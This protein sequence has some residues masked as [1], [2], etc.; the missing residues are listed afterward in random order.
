MVLSATE[1]A[2]T[3]KAEPNPTAV[4]W[5][6]LPPELI[7]TIAEKLITHTD[8][9]RFRAVSTTWRLSTPTAPLH[10]P[11]QLPWLMLPFNQ[12]RRSAQGATRHL[13]VDGLG[14]VM[15]FGPSWFL[16]RL[17]LLFSSFES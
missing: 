14:N 10:L 11:T 16:A 8:Y 1:K 7:Q 4:D 2:L 17:G 5:S 12:T 3:T 15:G 9:L 13:L 6:E